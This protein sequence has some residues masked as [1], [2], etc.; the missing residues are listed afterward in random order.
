MLLVSGLM[1][2]AAAERIKA[3]QSI[4][5]PFEGKMLTVH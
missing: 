2:L 4:F 1:Q 5:S 3:Q